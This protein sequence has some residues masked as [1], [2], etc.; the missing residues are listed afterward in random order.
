MVQIALNS[1]AY[2]SESYISNSQR[3]VNLYAERNPEETKPTFPT[4][5][6]VRPG[7]LLL[8]NVGVLGF[9]RCLYRATNGDLYAVIGQN[10]Y[11]IDPNWTYKQIGVVI[12]N[13]STPAYM[14]DNGT[15]IILVDGSP[16]GYTI[17]LKTRV[18]TQ[19]TDPN[20]LGSTRVDFIDSFLILNNPGTNQWYCTLSDD[21]T[22][23]ALYIGIKTAWPDNILCCVA[24]ERE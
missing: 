4:T 13:A 15:N 12:T 16:Q 5:Q 7:L 3:S 20:F 17:N 11:Y 1:G 19:I 23:N 6:Y 22:F 21:V 14:A 10:V 8:S 24:I 2:S 9:S 18:F